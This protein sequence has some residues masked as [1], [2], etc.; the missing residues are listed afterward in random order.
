MSWELLWQYLQQGDLV[1]F[2]TAL[3]TSVLGDLFY[4]LILL[5][6]TLPLYIRTQSLSYVAVLWIV[7]SGALVVLVPAEAQRLLRLLFV[8]GVA[9]IL[10]KLFVRSSP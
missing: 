7:L 2:A 6:L 9:A 5:A 10:L 1:G 4:A 8:L 3:F